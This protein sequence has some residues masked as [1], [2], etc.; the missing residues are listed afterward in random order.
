MVKWRAWATKNRKQIK[1]KTTVKWVSTQFTHTVAQTQENAD[2]ERTNSPVYSL[3]CDVP[4]P[5]DVQLGEV[6]GVVHEQ[7]EVMVCEGAKGWQVQ[8]L[9]AFALSDQFSKAL[10]DA[11]RQPEIDHT[12]MNIHIYK[13]MQE[14][15]TRAASL[16][17]GGEVIIKKTWWG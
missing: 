1:R 9:E 4:G 14:K 12:S 8:S 5:H 10:C 15:D 11:S 2:E 3:R 7:V 16:S 13:E 6:P 17:K